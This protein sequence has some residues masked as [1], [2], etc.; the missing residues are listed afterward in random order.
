[1]QRTKKW[2]RDLVRRRVFITLL[3]LLQLILIAYL[4][5]SG[6]KRVLGINIFLNIISI[7]VAL[8]IIAKK[9]KGA[10]KLTWVFIILVFP[11]FG[12]LFYLLFKLQSSTRAFSRKLKIIERRSKKMS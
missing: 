3:I 7:V 6:S 8:H 2:F 5:V 10:Y 9:D 11:L 4:I 12:G 1:M